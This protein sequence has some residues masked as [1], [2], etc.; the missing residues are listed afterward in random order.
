[1]NTHLWT[2]GWPH[3]HCELT[4]GFLFVV[5][6]QIASNS[7]WFSASINTLDNSMVAGRWFGLL[8]WTDFWYICRI[9]V[10]FFWLIKSLSLVKD[11]NSISEIHQIQ[12]LVLSLLIFHIKIISCIFC[13]CVLVWFK[14]RMFFY[15]KSKLIS[16]F[17]VQWCFFETNN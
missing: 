6:P 10:A 11:N 17:Y 8:F 12:K 16:V 9:F 3:Y 2:H 1:M 7:D 14:L 15:V 4:D 13:G 5:N